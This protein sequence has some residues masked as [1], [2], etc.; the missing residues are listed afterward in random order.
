MGRLRKKR[1]LSPLK[2]K[3]EKSNKIDQ[4]GHHRSVSSFQLYHMLANFLFV[5]SN[6][7]RFKFFHS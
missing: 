6:L 4:E 5:S 7:A 3:K 2:P 1:P